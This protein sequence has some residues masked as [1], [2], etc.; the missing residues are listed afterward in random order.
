MLKNLPNR[1]RVEGYTD[2]VPIRNA[3]YPVELGTVGGARAASVVRS[4]RAYRCRYAAHGRDRLRRAPPVADNAS[5]DGR[6]R[7]RRVVMVVLNQPDPRADVAV[8]PDAA[9]HQR[10][11]CHR[12]RRDCA[13]NSEA[14]LWGVAITA[15]V[16]ANIVLV[17]LAV[18]VHR[19]WRT[20][21]TQ[22]KDS[23]SEAR[24]CSPSCARPSH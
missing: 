1:V 23:A 9:R 12:Y 4:A 19:R 20:A 21:F 13:M 3:V 7:N 15:I 5:A 6:L 8:D 16:V 2:N 11:A 17:A 10:P 22:A 14:L 18:I 24:R